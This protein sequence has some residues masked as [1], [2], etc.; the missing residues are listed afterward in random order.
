MCI[1]E[2]DAIVNTTKINEID[3][4]QIIASKYFIVLFFLKTKK[5]KLNLVHKFK[6]DESNPWFWSRIV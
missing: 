1:I 5:I 6:I 4:V 2:N 3:N